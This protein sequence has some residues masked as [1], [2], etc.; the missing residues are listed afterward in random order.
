MTQSKKMQTPL[1]FTADC[2]RVWR[3][4][5]C[6]LTLLACGTVPVR[7][8]DGMIGIHEPSTV[9]ECDGSYYV[10]GTGRGIS[11]PVSSN[12]FNWERGQRVFDRIPETVKACVPKNNGSDAWAPDIIRSN[13]EYYLYN[14]ISSWGQ[15]VLGGRP[16]DQPGLGTEKSELPLDGPGHGGSFRGGGKPQRD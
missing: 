5:L 11:V 1:D 16:D 9:I 15:Y 7:A 13:G 3:A 14:A 8:L 12:G 10:Y 4:M 2:R 6:A